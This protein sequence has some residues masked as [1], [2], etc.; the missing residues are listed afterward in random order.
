[1]FVRSPQDPQRS[2]V[3]S[4]IVEMDAK[5][6]ELAKHTRWGMRI[7]H[8]V[9]YRPR[10]PTLRV[11]AVPKRQ[12]GILMPYHKPVGLGRLVEQRCAEWSRLSTENFLRYFKQARLPSQSSNRRVAQCVAHASL[13]A[14]QR[15]LI[16]VINQPPRFLRQ[17]D[18]REN[19]KAVFL[20]NVQ[21]IHGATLSRY[22]REAIPQ[23]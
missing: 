1:M 6:Q 16:E 23:F 12:G 20:D 3:G 9:L 13:A 10:S 18:L 22:V 4:G 8:A 7:D 11:V 19:S 14:P 5:C 17:E 2:I 21:H 15:R